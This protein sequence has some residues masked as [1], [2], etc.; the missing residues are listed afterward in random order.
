[1]PTSTWFHAINYADTIKLMLLAAF[2]ATV[3]AA[4]GDRMYRWL[5]ITGRTLAPLLVLGS[6]DF[7]AANPVFAAALDLSLIALLLWAAGTARQL[8]RGPA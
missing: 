8:S 4:A 2:A 7:V 3:T 5:R 1:M 6:L